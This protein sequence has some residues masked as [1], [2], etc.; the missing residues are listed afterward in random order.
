MDLR[1][2]IGTIPLVQVLKNDSAGCDEVLVT[3]KD[4]GKTFVEVFS[5]KP[6][7]NWCIETA[8]NIWNNQ[9]TKENR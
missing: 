8:K 7:P 1:K 5:G 6:A 4:N 2:L 3:S 9:I